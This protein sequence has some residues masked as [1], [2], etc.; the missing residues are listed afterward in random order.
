MAE[1]SL[2]RLDKHRSARQAPDDDPDYDDGPAGEEDD[3]PEDEADDDREDDGAVDGASAD[4]EPDVLL[5]VPTL[6]V[7]EI[8]L[9]VEDLEAHVSLQAEVLSL[10]KLQ[11]GA[12]VSLGRVSLDIKGVEAVARLKVRLDKVEQTIDRVMTTIDNNPQILTDLTRGVG[13][14]ASQIG[15]GAGGAL[16]EVGGG[17]GSAVESVGSGVRETVGDLGRSAGHAVEGVLEEDEDEDEGED[18]DLDE[19]ED[20][21]GGEDEEAPARRPVARSRR[22]APPPERPRPARGNRRPR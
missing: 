1:R 9:E 10:L 7:E 20:D 2:A 5:D 16:E 18:E 14:A 6:K 22:A 17:A 19:D 21:E 12:D 8:D 13:E 11:V 15:H 3:W 4:A